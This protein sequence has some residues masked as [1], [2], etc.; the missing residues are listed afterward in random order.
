MYRIILPLIAIVFCLHP[1]QAQE[2]KFDVKVVIPVNLKTDPSVY[3]QMETD[4]KDFFNKT[5]WTDHEYTEVEKI[6]G[7]VQ[8]TVTEELSSSTFLADIT[9]KTSR[10]VYNSDYKTQ[11]IN[12]QDKSVTFTYLP[13]QPIQRSD[14][15]FFDNLSSTLSFYAFLTLGYD[16]DSFSL[17]GGE[18][19]F[20]AARD[21]FQ[22]LPNGTKRDD[23]SW[24]NVGV[25]GRSK[26]FLIENIQSPRLR[27]FRQVIYEYHRLALDNMWQDAEKSRAVLLSSLGLI[28]DL[29]QAYPYS[30]FL[31]SFGDAKFNELVEIFKAADTGQKAKLRALM[32]LTSP[33]LAS[34][35]DAL[36]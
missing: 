17:Y 19:Y 24:S 29:N 28:E 7:S 21:V 2:L 15:S 11:M 20:Q 23:P 34:R 14:R 12:I 5:R 1:A 8:I 27:P 26:Y 10:P 22:N 31:Q 35:Y 25:N 18:D 32:T 16:Y 30:Y 3:R 13:G 9:L 33:S 36:K 4:V 6:E